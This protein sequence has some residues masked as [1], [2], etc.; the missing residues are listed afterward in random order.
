MT[1]HFA[2]PWA[3]PLDSDGAV[4]PGAQLEFFSAS[5]TTPI[6]VYTN[7]SRSIAHT[8]PVVA[9]SSGR[10]APIFLPIGTYDVVLKDADGVEV[11]RANALDGSSALDSQNGIGTLTNVGRKIPVGAIVP[12]SLAE[13]PAGFLRIKKNKQSLLK[14]EYPE[15]SAKYALESYPYGSTSETFNIPGGAGLF[16]RIWDDTSTWDPDATGRFANDTFATAVGNLIGSFQS[17]NVVAHTHGPGTLNGTTSEASDHNHSYSQPGGSVL[18]RGDGTPTVSVYNAVSV[19]STSLN[20]RHTHTTTITGGVTGSF[21]AGTETRGAN[22]AFPY[23]IFVNPAAAAAEETP[24]LGLPYRFETSTTDGEP[25]AGKLRLNNAAAAS[26]TFI[27]LS[28]SDQNGTTLAAPWTAIN[29]LTGSDRARLALH[30]VNSLGTVVYYRVSGAVTDATTY[31]K[32]PVVHLAG[33]PTFGANALLSMDLNQAGPK[34]DTGTAGTAGTAGA[35]GDHGTQSGRR[36][37][38]S[39][40]TSMLDPSDGFV[41]LNNATA[42]AVTRIAISYTGGDEG[43]T[44]HEG[45]V[46]DWDQSTTTNNRGYLYIEQIGDESKQACF[47]ITGSNADNTTW[48]EVTVEWVS[49]PGGFTN[50]EDLSVLWVRTGD[51]GTDGIGAGDVTAAAAFAADNRLIRSDGTGKGVQPTG[52]AVDDSDNVSGVV[53]LTMTGALTMSEIAAPSTPASGKVVIYPKTDGRLYIKDDA[54]TE[55]DLMAVGAGSITPAMMRG[56]ISG[57]VLANNVSD[58]NNDVD[59]SAGC[60]CADNQSAVMVLA[61]SITKRLDA[62]WA[63]G[64]GN[65]GLDTGT[66]AANTTYFA[67]LI[68]RSDTEVEDVLLS[69]SATAP[70][71]PTSYDRKALIGAVITNASS[72]IKAFTQI[73]DTFHWSTSTLDYSTTTLDTTAQTV[74]LN[75]ATSPGVPIGIAVEAIMEGGVSHASASRFVRVSSLLQ[76]DQAPLAVGNTSTL[77]SVAAATQ[78]GQLRVTTNS[79]GQLR[80]DSSGSA[81]T[82]QLSVLAWRMIRS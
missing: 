74:T 58:A 72:N 35:A 5:T 77:V 12:H 82:L 70:V 45:W 43:E 2:P 71:M 47:V 48:A 22:V 55:T 40:T 76:T 27:Y 60:A 44:D 66:K 62:A 10:F 7:A 31:W 6:V 29:T 8:W 79:S 38:F 15:L 64:T 51:K 37:S 46:K 21:G 14:S 18:V 75:A 54:G 24:A 32:I 78:V 80:V 81:T 25:A 23:I 61:S 1:L 68:Q 53:A 57:L 33:T 3:Q 19:Q 13:V 17:S 65:G 9:N 73:G 20:G 39:T 26:A 11:A 67:W 30:S 69:A 49:G 34:G 59:V 50:F 56:Y 16:A 52:I 41:R 36:Y 63:V 42:T 4:L 28:K